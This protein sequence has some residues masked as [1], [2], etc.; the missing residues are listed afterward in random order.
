M[1]E[2]L[3]DSEEKRSIKR[4]V[5]AHG[6]KISVECRVGKGTRFTITM[7]VKPRDEGGEKVWVNVPE[8]LLLTTTK[9]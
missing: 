3:R 1:E 9:A 7:P 6:G 5:E 8:S 4:F 2:A